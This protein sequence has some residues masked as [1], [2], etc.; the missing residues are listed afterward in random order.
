MSGQYFAEFNE[1]FVGL[2]YCFITGLFYLYNH[3]G[4]PFGADTSVLESLG[5]NKITASRF[6]ARSSRNG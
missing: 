4:G 6:G 1:F 3:S 5:S 2:Y